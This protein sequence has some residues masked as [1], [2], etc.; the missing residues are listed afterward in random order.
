MSGEKKT[1]T[2][3]KKANTTQEVQVQAE[4]KV[5]NKQG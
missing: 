3:L 1:T 2:Q 5:E 4:G